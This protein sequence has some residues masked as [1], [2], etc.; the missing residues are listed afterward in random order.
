MWDTL[1]VISKMWKY[2]LPVRSQERDCKV[3]YC[4]LLTTVTY[5]LRPEVQGP[6]VRGVQCRKVQR[7]VREQPLSC[8]R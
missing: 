8:S 2:W 5:L 3:L 4:H 7:V 6:L 1:D